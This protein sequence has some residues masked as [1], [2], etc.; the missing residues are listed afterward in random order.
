M[1][2]ISS[3]PPLRSASR[4]AE[5]T[6]RGAGRTARRWRRFSGARSDGFAGMASGCAGSWLTMRSPTGATPLWRSVSASACGSYARA[7]YAADER[8]GG[9]LHPDAPCASG[10]SSAI[11]NL[12][13]A[14]AGFGWLAALLRRQSSLRGE[15]P[16]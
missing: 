11:R 7:R 2:A 3:R 4:A 16:V 10:V 12:S 9:A 8:Q 1:R 5:L 15:P 13:G 14:D 6:E